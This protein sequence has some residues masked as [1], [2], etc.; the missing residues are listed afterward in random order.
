MF[1]QKF[2]R[3]L[4]LLAQARKFGLDV[5]QILAAPA[6]ARPFEPPLSQGFASYRHFLRG[7]G[8]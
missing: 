7:K 6:H 5:K 1:L 3:G 4:H 8:C 2:Y